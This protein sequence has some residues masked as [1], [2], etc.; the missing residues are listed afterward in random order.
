MKPC[1]IGIDLGTT[2]CKLVAIDENCNVI[3]EAFR[4][5]PLHIPRPGWSEQNPEDWWSQ[6]KDGLREL[7][8][9]IG[10]KGFEISAIGLSGT[11]S[12][13]ILLNK[14]GK[15]LRP[16]I[17]WND[18]RSAKQAEFATEKLGGERNVL[19]LI[20]NVIRA[21]H[22]L[23]KLLWVRENEASIFSEIYKFILPKDY[24]AYKL[25]GRIITD[26]CYASGTALFDVKN[27]KW[28]YE[29]L[30]EFDLNPD[31][32]PEVVESTSV[33]GE[34]NSVI[35]DELGLKNNI[36]VIIGGGDSALQTITAGSINSKSLSLVI[37]TAGITGVTID[38]YAENPDGILHVYCN[39]I[40]G[41]WFIYGCSLSAG[42]SLEWFKEILASSE[43]DVANLLNQSVFEILSNEASVA[44]P[45]SGGLIFFPFLTGERSPYPNP[46]ARGAFIGLSLKTTKRELVRS[47]MEGVAYNMRTVYDLMKKNFGINVEKIYLSGGG[48]TS[49]VW[50]QVFADVFNSEV[51]VLKHSE[52]GGALGSAIV[53]GVGSGLIKSFE[54]AINHL[55]V[56][57][58][59]SPIPENVKIY[60]KFVKAYQE[61]YE[62][63]KPGFDLMTNIGF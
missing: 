16:C 40:P 4:K 34:I 46:N 3:G 53:A 31:I 42:G 35:A 55:E 1:L 2:S 11:M 36:P 41:K 45:G 9:H 15:V 6:V 27:R 24:L 57:H 14:E 37:G 52:I 26:V 32:L 49:G 25:T 28:C 19:R 38:D 51:L 7:A 59:N 18:Q 13:L 5:Y 60:K 54:D 50:R 44:P 17:M 20:N 33:I 63:I 21:G 47:V 39:V 10:N 8:C 12:G 61:L 58:R 22:I 62:I 30:R 23:P 48:A 43:K 56:V 29:I